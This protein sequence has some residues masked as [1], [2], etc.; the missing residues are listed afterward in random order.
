MLCYLALREHDLSDLQLRLAEK[1]LSSLGRLEGQV[2]VILEKVM[3]HLG[4]S[5]YNN[6]TSLCKPNTTDASPLLG[7]PRQGRNTRIM[8]TLDSSNIH[9]PERIG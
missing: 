1:G 3:R 9:Q 7:R 5:V 6:T 2:M 8:V 4:V